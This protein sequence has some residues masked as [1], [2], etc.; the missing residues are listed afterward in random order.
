MLLLVK[1]FMRARAVS[2]GE[3]GQSTSEYALVIVAV[4]AIG[5]LL[6]HWVS[7]SGFFDG[8]FGKIGGL[9]TSFF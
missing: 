9:I 1:L 8:L 2:R 5:G 7:G 4:V 3:R 6:I